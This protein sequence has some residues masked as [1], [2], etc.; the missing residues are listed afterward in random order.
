[1]SEGADYCERA[2]GIADAGVPE[3]AD[4]WLST[5]EEAASRK[6]AGREYLGRAE[7][8]KLLM[9]VSV[10]ASQGLVRGHPGILEVRFA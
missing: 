8:K 6:E 2:R 9:R 1:M 7:W 3:H 4:S 5:I 10:P